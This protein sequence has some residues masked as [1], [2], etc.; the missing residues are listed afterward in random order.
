[1]LEAPEPSTDD[2]TTATTGCGHAPVSD[3]H[4]RVVKCRPVVG[5]AARERPLGSPGGLGRAVTTIAKGRWLSSRHDRRDL[6]R[7]RHRHQ[8]PLER[9]RLAGRG[10]ENVPA[11]DEVTPLDGELHLLAR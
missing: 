10:D 9:D 6:V 3:G 4:S 11:E 7:Q 5:P 1:R 2:D 8:T